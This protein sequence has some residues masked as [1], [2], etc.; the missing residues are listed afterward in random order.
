MEL[1]KPTSDHIAAVQNFREKNRSS[2]YF[3]H[4]SAISESIPALGWVCV[5]SICIYVCM[6]KRIKHI[7]AFFHAIFKEP[8]PGP[9]VKEMNDA[10]Q[11]YTNRV[12]KEWKEK[13]VVHV[14][15]TRAWIQ[16]L[17]DLQKYIKQYHTTGLVWSGK[18]TTTSSSSSGAPLPPPPPPPLSLSAAELEK[19]SLSGTDERS[20]LFAEINQGETITKSKRISNKWLTIWTVYS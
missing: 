9:H 20:A 7:V 8:T 15:W 10:G 13:N 2:Q 19:M 4:L 12:L 14:E 18:N 6:Y 17:N 5:V 1:L 11:F 16:T 3:N